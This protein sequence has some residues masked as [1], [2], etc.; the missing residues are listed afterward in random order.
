M[1]YD[2]V[3]DMLMLDYD[4]VCDMVMIRV[5]S[6]NMCIRHS[7]IVMII[8]IKEGGRFIKYHQDEI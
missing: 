2:D 5:W 3:C 7:T 8:V 4:D 1:D 6:D